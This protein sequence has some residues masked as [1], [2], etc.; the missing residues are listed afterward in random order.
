VLV[1]DGDGEDDFAGLDLEGR[2]LVVVRLLGRACDGQAEDGEEG[3]RER[4]RRWDSHGDQRA[5]SFIWLDGGV[6]AGLLG[7]ASGG[8]S[9]G[10]GGGHGFLRLG[11]VMAF[12]GIGSE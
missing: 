6:G 1:A 5:H 8:V 9:G 2:G 10:V 7:V 12:F 4:G 11:S 3:K